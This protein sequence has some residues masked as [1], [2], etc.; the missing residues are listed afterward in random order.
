MAYANAMRW[1]VVCA[2]DCSE[3][4]ALSVAKGDVSGQQRD[5]KAEGKI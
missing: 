3:D 1:K 5:E 2:V 4:D